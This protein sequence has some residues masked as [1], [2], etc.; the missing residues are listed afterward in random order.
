MSVNSTSFVGYAHIHVNMWYIQRNC[1]KMVDLGEGTH[2]CEIQPPSETT[3]APPAAGFNLIA[4]DVETLTS[5]RTGVLLPYLGECVR[6]PLWLYVL[7]IVSGD[8]SGFHSGCAVKACNLC[9]PAF[10]EDNRELPHCDH[11]G[12]RKRVF[13][14]VKEIK[15]F[16][17]YLFFS[18][19]FEK[20]RTVI[21]FH[22]R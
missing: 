13:F 21:L 16:F 18:R 6:Y 10:L 7:Y 15:K 1:K 2:L 5:R 4:A 3:C 20:L 17:S 12:E 22:N 14:G 9:L 19:E 11:C 8:Y